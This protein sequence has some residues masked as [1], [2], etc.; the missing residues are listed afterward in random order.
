[1]DATRNSDCLKF[2][3]LVHT[4]E[5]VE[6]GEA[7]SVYVV[8]GQNKAAPPA[9]TCGAALEVGVYDYR[10]APPL[11]RGESPVSELAVD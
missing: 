2:R 9:W 3:V 4:R 10:L 5:R 8:A 7:H 6:T 1:M 11:P